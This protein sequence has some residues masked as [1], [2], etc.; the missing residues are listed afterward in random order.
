MAI[1]VF[2]FCLSLMY[3]FKLKPDQFSGFDSRV[4]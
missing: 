3:I 2:I 4:L 1:F